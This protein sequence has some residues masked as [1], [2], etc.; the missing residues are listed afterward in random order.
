MRSGK[1][2]HTV[3]LQSLVETQDGY[4]GT[5]ESWTD[6]ATVRASVEPLQG[7]EYFAAQQE[8]AEVTTRFRIR[9]IPGVLP[10]MR[11]MFDGRAFNIESIIN[12]NERNREL[13]L[14]AVEVLDG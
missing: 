3:T 1:L 7:R 12:P 14:M 11:I 2:R 5:T 13:H 10:T 6:F 4:G 9:Y 8:R